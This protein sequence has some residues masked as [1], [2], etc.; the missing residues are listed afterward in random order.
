MVFRGVSVLKH[1]HVPLSY[2]RFFGLGPDFSVPRN[3]RNLSTSASV[4]RQRVRPFI[5]VPIDGRILPLATHR[6]RVIQETPI[7]FAA[8]FVEYVLITI[9]VVSQYY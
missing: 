9:H 1:R 6:F 2:F 5:G 7:S 3:L 8:C 4:K